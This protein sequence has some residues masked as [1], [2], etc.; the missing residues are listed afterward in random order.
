MLP[1]LDMLATRV[2][3]NLGESLTGGRFD[4][5]EVCQFGGVGVTAGDEQ[6]GFHAYQAIP[7]KDF[8]SVT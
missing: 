1:A 7:G 2:R 6:S 5:V 3:R 4:I 8:S